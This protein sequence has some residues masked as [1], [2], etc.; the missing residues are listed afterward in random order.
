VSNAYGVLFVH[1]MSEFEMDFSGNTVLNSTG[2]AEK[3]KINVSCE[4]PEYLRN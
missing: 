3:N 1:L 4:S 2:R